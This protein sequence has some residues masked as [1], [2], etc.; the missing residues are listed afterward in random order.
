LSK[1]RFPA[2][3]PFA[4]VSEDYECPGCGSKKEAFYPAASK[5]AN[6]KANDDQVFWNETKYSDHKE[7]D[8]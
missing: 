4:E 3:T 7:S 5:S 8:R 1:N 6:T 2:G